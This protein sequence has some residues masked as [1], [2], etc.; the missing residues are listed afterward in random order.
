MFLRQITTNTNEGIFDIFK[1]KKELKDSPEFKGWL[2]IY[3]KNP[4]VAAMHAKHKEFLQYYNENI[5]EAPED[6]INKK[7]VQKAQGMMKPMYSS[8]IAAMVEDEFEAIR[9]AALKKFKESNGT[10]SLY[11]AYV[12]V[13]ED[14]FPEIPYPG[15]VFQYMTDPVDPNHQDLVP[16][17]AEDGS[18]ADRIEKEYEQN[19]NSNGFDPLIK[20]RWFAIKADRDNYFDQGMEPEDALEKAAER[21]GV[22]PEELQKWIEAGNASK[23][24]ENMVWSR[25]GGK[26]VRKYRC[27]SGVRKGRV[28][29]SPASCN[30]PLDVSKG[31]TLKKTKASKAGKVNMT[32]IR[33]RKQNPRSR[34]LKVIN[35]PTNIKRGGRI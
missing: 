12:L 2:N 5:K 23:F 16:Q 3:L 24:K 4:D 18:W 29:A 34:R 11:T 9:D 22:D 10:I 19:S 32:G 33:T 15:V 35:K 8:E 25:Q 21:H 20:G 17:E 30:K 14:Q 28:M 26:Q 6:K 27:T 13:I 1:S 31:Q 7:I